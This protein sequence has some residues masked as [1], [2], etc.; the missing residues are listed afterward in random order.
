MNRIWYI[1]PLKVITF[2]HIPLL[3][4]AL[5][6]PEGWYI[7][8]LNSVKG[9]NFYTTLEA[10]IC[11]S[12]FMSAYF[13]AYSS[14]PTNIA[15]RKTQIES[16]LSLRNVHAITYSLF[17]VYIAANVILL[18]QF[19]QNPAYFLLLASTDVEQGYGRSLATTI[20][21]LTTLTQ[22]GILL[23]VISATII[24]FEANKKKQ[25]TGWRIFG[26][27]LL[28]SILRAFTRGERLALLEVLV[29]FFVL[30]ASYKITNRLTLKYAPAFAVIFLIFIFGAFEYFRSW[31][32]FY[33]T[34]QDN[35]AAFILSRI[36]SYFI[37]AIN[38]GAYLVAHDQ[39]NEHAWMTMRWLYSFPGLSQLNDIYDKSYFEF[40]SYLKLK[41]NPEFNNVSP[42]YALIL[43][44]G[45]IGN[46]FAIS[47]FGAITGYLFKQ[48]KRQD[49]IGILLFPIWYI[50]ILEFSRTFSWGSSRF[51]PPLVTGLLIALWFRQ[52]RKP[53]LT[54]N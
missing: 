41:L 39:F 17:A 50:G 2:I 38:T 15:P 27:I 16:Y 13:V 36:S 23:S 1:H 9:V 40:M 3:A 44:F 34:T 26:S 24:C 7:S 6:L 49:I 19:I 37:G 48:F 22:L 8:N 11:V 14:L 53:T 28:F 32:H 5:A 47:T 25:K 52:R 33:A 18:F 12:A 29:P 54:L 43:D 31:T 51:F 21:G 45:H 42:I 4:L 46:P 20:P 30:I 10:L 35:Y